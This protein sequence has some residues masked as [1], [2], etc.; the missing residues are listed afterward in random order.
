MNIWFDFEVMQKMG[1][2][3]DFNIDPQLLKGL[4]EILRL[5]TDRLK[6]LEDETSKY[7]KGLSVITTI[8]NKDVPVQHIGFPDYLTKKLYDCIKDDD[9]KFIL[10]NAVEKFNSGLN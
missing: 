4:D 10:K 1:T 2:L 6:V 8:L 3:S 5:V 9:I 7:P